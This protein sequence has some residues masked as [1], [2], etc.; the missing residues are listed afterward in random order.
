MPG[1]G[2]GDLAASPPV[3]WTVSATQ[4]YP[5]MGFSILYQYGLFKQKIVDG[6]ADRASRCLASGR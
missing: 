2:M 3:F 5:A 1:S 4:N 6:L